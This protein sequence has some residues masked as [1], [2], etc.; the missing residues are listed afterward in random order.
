[1][2]KAQ[3]RDRVLTWL[4]PLVPAAVAL[5]LLCLTLLLAERIVA[6]ELQRRASFRVEQAAKLYADQLSR[7]L[8]Q[9]TAELHLVGEMSRTGIPLAQWRAQMQKLKATT[10]SYVWIGATDLNGQVQAATDGLLEGV[11]IATRGVYLNGRNGLWFGSLHPPVA[12]REPLRSLGR[13]I[14]LEL[15]DI[16]MPVMDPEGVQRGV[17][18][19]HLDARYFEDLRQNVLGPVEA[20]R[21]LKL[22]L[23]DGDGRV[24]LGEG[25]DVSEADWRAHLL[26]RG[27][28][29]RA[30]TDGHG[31]A[32]YLSRSPVIPTDSALRTEWQV[33]GSQPLNAALAPVHQLQRSLLTWGGLTTL[34]LGIAGFAASRR[35][36]RPYS[37]SEKYLREQGEVLTAVINAASDAVISVDLNGRITLFNP[38][39]ARIFGRTADAMIGQPL[40]VLLPQVHRTQH[41]GYLQRF[42]ESQSTTRPMGVGRVSGLRADGQVLE[43]EASISQI[44][45]RGSKLLTAIL[46]D[47][48]ERVRSE[49]E[50]AQ[51]QRELSELTR[52]LLQ[53]EKHTTRKLAQTLHDQLGQT[54]GAIRLSYDAFT[55][56]L[57]PELS[58]KARERERKLADM[59]DTAN[60]EVRQALVE[61][62]PPLL[63]EAGLQ[64][65]LENEVQV[66]AADAEPVALRLTIEP[67]AAD[68]RWPADVEYAAFMVA[69]EA[70]ANAVLHA[71]ASEVVVR[72]AGHAAHLHLSVIDDGKGLSEELATGRPGHLG[73][74]GMRERALAIGGRMDAHGWAEGGTEISLI[75]DKTAQHG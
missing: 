11:S 1:M 64:A 58:P 63:D 49:R 39:A 72:I 54:L 6:G 45:V 26:D 33:V 56:L 69:R 17:I 32:H 21:F 43:L 34:L 2:S 31:D 29:S 37:E 10:G 5:A 14:P 8:A 41:V 15:A 53:Q 3:S 47:V 23:V 50:L 57:P 30:F 25:P 36:S 9:R 75:W 4:L 42:A 28:H 73:I 35:L 70:L 7:M 12:L 40:D 24:L 44:T 19:T 61:L 60:A 27:E 62:R 18:A 66:R 16:A 13:P 22:A 59:I 38:A 51:Y 46:R 48:T 20:R 55:G 52:R 65:A 67:S 74:V 71:D 68:V